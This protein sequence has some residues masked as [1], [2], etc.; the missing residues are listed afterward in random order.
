MLPLCSF[1]FAKGL[2]H[3]LN[4]TNHCK[5]VKTWE[6]ISLINHSVNVTIIVKHWEII[7][8]WTELMRHTFLYEFALWKIYLAQFFN[9]CGRWRSC[10]LEIFPLQ[11]L[12][13][14][15]QQLSSIAWILW[16]SFL[17]CFTPNL[18]YFMD[19]KVEL[20]LY[21]VMYFLQ[22]FGYVPLFMPSL[23]QL[24]SIKFHLEWIF[25]SFSF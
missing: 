1:R 7:S 23:Q 18:F 10:H 19:R 8:C 12:F 25:L 2:A 16:L 22:M 24:F 5:I 3:S 9:W 6:M 13:C 17:L 11:R 4:E 21:F 14:I 15:I 20:Y